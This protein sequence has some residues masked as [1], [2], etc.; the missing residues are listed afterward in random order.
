MDVLTI[1]KVIGALGAVIALW[2]KIYEF[3]FNKKSR[4][5]EEYKFS[6]NFLSDINECKLH[7]YAIEIGYQA[8][9]GTEI[10]KPNEI[11]YILSLENPA[12][13]LKDYILS[14]QLMEKLETKGNLSLKFKKKY[15]KNWSRKWRKGMYFSLYMVFAFIALSPVI[16]SKYINI[17]FSKTFALLV[18]SLPFGG[19]YAWAALNAHSKIKR[20]EHLMT[21]QKQHTQR[22]VIE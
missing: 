4:L 20:G 15:I 9:A 22:V 11:E 14:R 21:N 17:E 18:I 7:P 2:Y 10:V 19:I 16:V 3:R 8:I 6:K 1:V 13:C 12:Q 5:R